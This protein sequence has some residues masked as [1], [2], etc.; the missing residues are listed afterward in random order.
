V[1][2]DVF[3]IPSLR[4]IDHW[5]AIEYLGVVEGAQHNI[6]VDGRQA[7]EPEGPKDYEYLEEMRQF[8]AWRAKDA[9]VLGEANVE[10]SELPLYFGDGDRVQMLLNFYVNQQLF[11]SIARQEAAPLVR[12][13][14]SLPTLPETAQWGN[15]LRN[16]DEIDL[17]RLTEAERQHAFAEFGPQP[18][19]QLYDR[20]VRR[21][22]APMLG[23]DLRRLA[24]AYSLMFTLPGTPVLRYG[25][26]LGMLADSIND[27][28]S[29]RKV[30]LLAAG[31]T[32]LGVLTIFGDS[33]V[34][35]L[36]PSGDTP[37]APTATPAA[38][39]SAR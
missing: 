4:R 2:G 36:F 26:E 5:P 23:N 21:R 30:Y 10:L 17:G 29:T 39:R 15:F 31:L 33:L 12:A 8:L 28:S 24:L 18:T 22:L 34:A 13:I 38:E 14:E 11:N 1:R 35:A 7:D 9:I 19:M 27:V 3:R 37:G 6:W 16:H 32:L 25:D 20:G